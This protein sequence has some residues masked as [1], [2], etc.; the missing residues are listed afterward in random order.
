MLSD[1]NPADLESLVIVGDKSTSSSVLDQRSSKMCIRGSK[2]N[3]SIHIRVLIHHALEF[4]L[5]LFS[6]PKTNSLSGF[7]G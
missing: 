4:T 7:G 3:S 2:N 1:C 5:S 6:C